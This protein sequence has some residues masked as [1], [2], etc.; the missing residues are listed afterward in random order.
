MSRLAARDVLLT[1]PLHVILGETQLADPIHIV[2]APVLVLFV[3]H[4]FEK[5]LPLILERNP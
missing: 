3:V 1:M 2:F 4:E 5:V